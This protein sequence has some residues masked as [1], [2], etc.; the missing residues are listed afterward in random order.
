MILTGPQ[1][2]AFKTHET[3]VC[4]LMGIFSYSKQ[5]T[6]IKIQKLIHYYGQI[7]FT[8]ILGSMYNNFYLGKFFNI[9]RGDSKSPSRKPQ[10]S[11]AHKIGLIIVIYIHNVLIYTYVY[12]EYIIFIIII[13]LYHYKK[14]CL[15][16][17][18]V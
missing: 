10:I 8:L 7:Y 5:C 6:Y 13:N 15:I 12:V 16:C 4:L 14:C 17:N 2:M 3:K 11:T 1:N 9:F 18:A